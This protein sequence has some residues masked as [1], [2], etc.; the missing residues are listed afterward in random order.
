MYVFP[1]LRFS[2]TPNRS[3]GY[4]FAGCPLI[5]SRLQF[6]ITLCPALQKKPVLPSIAVAQGESHPSILNAVA[7][8][9]GLPKKDPFSP[10]YI[11]ALFLGHLMQEEDTE[12]E[13]VALVGSAHSSHF[14]NSSPIS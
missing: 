2:T 8:N 4:A 9:D 10:P 6:E 11:E 12:E 14:V 1:S 13:F 7:S 3:L 5:V